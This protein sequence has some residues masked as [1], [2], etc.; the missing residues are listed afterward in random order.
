MLTPPCNWA[1]CVS[2]RHPTNVVDPG[3]RQVRLSTRVATNSSSDALLLSLI[4]TD[5]ARHCD[6][7]RVARLGWIL[8]AGWLSPASIVSW[9]VL[10]AGVFY[11]WLKLYAAGAAGLWV[12]AGIGLVGVWLEHRQLVALRKTAPANQT[13]WVND[14]T[15]RLARRL[16]WRWVT[17]IVG[18]RVD[19]SSP[20]SARSTP[21]A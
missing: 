17:A 13:P 20:K 6:V 8:V 10:V 4:V 11:R 18:P 15:S 21:S 7:S 12:A 1:I 5:A 9:L 16:P 3:T 2:D 19:L 14:S